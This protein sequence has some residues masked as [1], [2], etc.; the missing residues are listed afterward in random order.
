MKESYHYSFLTEEKERTLAA[1]ILQGDSRAREELIHSH[2]RMVFPIAKRFFRNNMIPLEDLIQEGNL[3]L[4]TAADNFD[5][6]KNIRFAAYARWW[7][8]EFIKRKFYKELYIVKTPLRVVKKSFVMNL[9]IPSENSEKKKGENRAIFN[10]LKKPLYLG[11]PVAHEN[12]QNGDREMQLE[13]ILN[14]CRDTPE[15]CFEKKDLR[16]FLDRKVQYYLSREESLVLK[17][18]FLSEDQR[19]TYKNLGTLLDISSETVRNIEKRAISKL[20][21]KLKKD[22]S[23]L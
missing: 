23:Y 13:T 3:G 6:T 8:V 5:A 20:K 21:K 10:I 1:K 17:R 9:G 4:I 18:R 14:D 22:F 2:L 19:L 7:I 15:E 11:S 12:P 16:K